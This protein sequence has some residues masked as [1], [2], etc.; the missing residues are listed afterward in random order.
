M[1]FEWLTE[2]ISAFAQ[3]RPEIVAVYLYGS[4]IKHQARPDSDVDLA[5]LMRS[6]ET[7]YLRAELTLEAALSR[8]LSK[9]EVEAL[10]LNH[11]PLSMQF[12]VLSTGRVL[13]SNDER[14]RT[15]WEVRSVSEYWDWQP[16]VREYNRVF[17]QRLT[18]GF[19]DAQQREY[20][21][22]RAALAG[23]P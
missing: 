11:A 3:N 8:Q 14:A 7:D 21:R 9:V 5:V 15:D 2:Q 4:Q 23:T 18:E 16:F 20:R 1:N 19:T 12:E 22:A 10:I 6:G 17:F 13:H